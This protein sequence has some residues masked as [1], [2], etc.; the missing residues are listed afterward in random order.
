MKAVYTRNDSVVIMNSN[1]SA[2]RSCQCGSWLDHWE[3]LSD[4]QA[5]KCSVAGCS[6]YAKVG[7]HVTRPKAEND[8]YKTAPYIVPMCSYH[9]SQHG[10]TFRSKPGVTFVWANKQQTCEA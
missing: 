1:G 5:G 2:G 3:N 7:A 10:E 6:E 9:N 8:A 4:L